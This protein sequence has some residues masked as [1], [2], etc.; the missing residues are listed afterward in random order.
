MHHWCVRVVKS[1]IAVRPPAPPALRRPSDTQSLS[2]PH[3]FKV[4][5]ITLAYRVCI[6]T[7]HCGKPHTRSKVG[8]VRSPVN[9]TWSPDTWDWPSFCSPRALPSPHWELSA[10][11]RPDPFIHTCFIK[12]LFLNTSLLRYNS[13]TITFSCLNYTSQWFYMFTEF[14]TH[15]H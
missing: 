14:C 11:L 5:C 13:H 3:C 8:S 15:H 10:N 2:A 4:S 9:C 7:F 1:T 12:Q 6:W